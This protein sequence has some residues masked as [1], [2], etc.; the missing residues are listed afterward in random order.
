MA[1]ATAAMPPLRGG[2]S[3]SSREWPRRCDGVLAV[4]WQWQVIARDP[5]LSEQTLR[6]AFAAQALQAIRRMLATS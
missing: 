4:V 6:S 3:G 2:G 1:G 5:E